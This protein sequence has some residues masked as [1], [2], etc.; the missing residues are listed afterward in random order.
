[1]PKQL[2][3][4]PA[5]HTEAQPQRELVWNAPATLGQQTI[6]ALQVSLS[7]SAPPWTLNW[8]RLVTIDAP[9]LAALVDLFGAWA[10]Q[11]VSL[12]FQGLA[13]LH[14]VLQAQT[15]AED[16]TADPQWWLLRMALLRL[17]D[18]ADD[19]EAVALDYCVTYEV[20]PPS[21]ADPKCGLLG[22]DV[23]ATHGQGD[24]AAMAAPGRPQAMDDAA[25]V[26]ELAGRS[27]E[28]RNPSSRPW[29]R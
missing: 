11:K 15:V 24:A 4:A 22:E 2:G 19:F 13:A 3:V 21:W 16:R 28:M 17:T 12:R 26:A 18:Q 29:R 6:A 27:K 25:P 5:A 7:R 23:P 20:S 9:A 8:G 14:K 1:M 10:N